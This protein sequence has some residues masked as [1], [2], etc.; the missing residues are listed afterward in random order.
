MAILNK[1]IRSENGFGVFCDSGIVFS[2]CSAVF[3]L[4]ASIALLDSFAALA[5]FLYFL[6]R[7]NSV[8]VNWPSQTASTNFLEKIHFILKGLSP[9]ENILGRPLQILTCG[10]FISVLFS[11]YPVL[12]L[13][14]FIGKFIKCVFLY[15][16][17]IEAFTDEKRIRIFLSVLF[18]SAF[19]TVLS[20]IYQHYMGRDFIKGILIG[21]ENFVST[22]R[23]S[24]T[25]YSANGFGAYLLPVIALAVQL[26]YTAVTSKKNWILAGVSALF[27]ILLLVSLC[28]T[29]SRSSWI[30]YFS[31][32]FA[33]ALLDR[34]KI[35]LSTAIFLICILIFLP[36]LD[37]VRHMHL[38]VDQDAA[39]QKS[40]SIGSL[41]EQGGSGRRA[42][43]E[44]A[45]SVIRT[46][47]VWGTGLNTYARIIM[48][49]PD[50]KQWWYAHNCYLQLTAETGLIGLLCFLWMLFVLL[51]NGFYYCHQIKDLWPLTFMQGAVSGLLGFL[52]QSFFDNT[53]YTVQLG[54]LMW[55]M[56]GL[57]VALIRL[58]PP[59]A[60]QH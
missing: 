15:F 32:L 28:W 50:T 11:Q 43:W 42:Y 6:K 21:T 9:P 26:L 17:F 41:L 4:P 45:I 40:E 1:S 27:L 60:S 56:F 31:I 7:M 3:V 36:S 37:K 22:H 10:V 13:T 25:F 53:F 51:R 47:P 35:I 12:S 52:V 59:A 2:I 20:G 55:M 48:K 34:R 44:K 33:M 54:V 39:L 5:I 49:N 23:I 38:I 29:Y 18:L 19:I 24:S 57:I 46:S 58:N 16:S 14:A 8:I 30:G